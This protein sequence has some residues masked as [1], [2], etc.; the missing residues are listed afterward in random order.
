MF[1]KRLALHLRALAAR[2]DPP[3][4]APLYQANAFYGTATSAAA[5]A[6]VRF[7]HGGSR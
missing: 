1:K 6:H 2:L 5:D 4:T 7:T 3:P